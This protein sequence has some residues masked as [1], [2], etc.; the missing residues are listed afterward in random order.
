MELGPTYV[1]V[2]PP[3]YARYESCPDVL[4]K[5]CLPEP[6]ARLGFIFL[7]LCCCYMSC[8]LM[9]KLVAIVDNEAVSIYDGVTRYPLGVT[10]STHTCSHEFDIQCG[11]DCNDTTAPRRLYLTA[12]YTV[13]VNAL[14]R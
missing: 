6:A 10:V 8:R 14:G 13:D 5:H 2:R 12:W 7:S 9:F 3:S 1:D 11:E 4:H